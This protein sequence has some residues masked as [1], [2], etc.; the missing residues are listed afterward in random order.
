MES[1]E[2][3]LD[4]A[5]GRRRFFG[6]FAKTALGV[7]TLGSLAVP[8]SAG[9]L[10]AEGARKSSAVKNIIVVFAA[11]GMSQIDTFDPKPGGE[12]QGPAKAIQTKTPGVVFGEAFTQLAGLTD[13]LA[14]IRSM[15][16]ETGDHQQG[17]YL[18]RTSYPVINSIR[19]PSFGSW[20]LHALGEAERELPGYVLVGGGNDHPGCGFLDPTLSPM[21]L[22]DPSAGISN[23]N[24]RGG[25]TAE[26]FNRRLRMTYRFDQAFKK[27]YRDPQVAAYDTMYRDAVRLM[28]SDDLGVFDLASESDAV[29]DA[30][31]RTTEG[32]GCLLARRLVEA[33]TPIVEVESGGWDGHS[34]WFKSL[35][36]KAGALD[37]AIAS[38][39]RDLGRRGLLETTLVVLTTEFGRTPSINKIGGRDHHP[40]VFS[41]ILAG[42]GVKA[43]GVYG[44]SD[45]HG[46]SPD[47]DPVTVRDFNTTVAAA[48]G[49][50]Y[51]R[52]FFAPNGRPFKIG[53]GGTPIAE[54]LS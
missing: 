25:V 32:Q 39:I 37:K 45:E 9:R 14:V 42:G 49:L 54:L 8:G 46:F 11:G 27:K 22:A 24:R 50:P 51:S 4:S 48:A 31:G 15:T 36:T 28:G 16:T 20:V 26:D 1:F 40:G 12:E 38:L 52:E 33:G 44:A 23:M 10:L 29:R 41:S 13:Q 18:M 19:H 47:R 5:I 6:R 17:C 30:Y 2:S 43:G 53:G 7:A 34:D 21:P 3:F 35:P